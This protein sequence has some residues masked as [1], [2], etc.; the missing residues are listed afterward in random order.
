MA[1]QLALFDTGPVLPPGF[2]YR[3]DAIAPAD[4]QALVARIA[5]LPFRE[6]EFHGH[7]GKRRVVSFG[8]RYD[9]ATESLQPADAVP[10]FLLP[11]RE[12]AARVAGLAPEALVQVLATEYDAGAGIGWHRD[13]GVFGTIVGVSLLAAC[14]FRLRRRAGERWERI[15]LTAERRSAYVL[16]GEARTAWEHGIPPVA[17]RRYSLTF[18][19]LR[20]HG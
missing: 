9:F 1:A 2:V 15:A 19:T 12:I 18:R 5:E 4:E 11:V 13:K 16:A 8:W 20:G 14:R 6:F 17:E 7:L 10:D 3:A